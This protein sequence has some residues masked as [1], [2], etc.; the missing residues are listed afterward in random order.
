MWQ[1]G[2]NT[3]GPGESYSARRA[4]E[5]A[6]ELPILDKTISVLTAEPGETKSRLSPEQRRID[7][8]RSADIVTLSALMI[9]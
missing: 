1:T 9:W 4:G 5:I 7:L 2:G 8:L 6:I 3:G